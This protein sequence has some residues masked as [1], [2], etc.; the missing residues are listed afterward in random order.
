MAHQSLADAAGWRAAIATMPALRAPCGHGPR[1]NSDPK[2]ERMDKH[3]VRKELYVSGDSPVCGIGEQ[4]VKYQDGAWLHPIAQQ[5][6]RIPG[7][8]VNVAI[9]MKV[10]HVSVYCWLVFAA[11]V[12][13]FQ[14]GR[15]ALVEETLQRR[16]GSSAEHVL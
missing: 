14:E 16:S 2:K 4:V 12:E 15:Q 5:R 3:H 6:Q 9:N 13:L 7:A 10:C 8:R 1:R 11:A